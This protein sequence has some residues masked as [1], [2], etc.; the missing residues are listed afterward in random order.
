[1]AMAWTGDGTMAF[2]GDGTQWLQ[3]AAAEARG[4]GGELGGTAPSSGMARIDDETTSAGVEEKSGNSGARLES[5]TSGLIG[6]GCGA[7]RRRRR[8]QRGSR[9]RHETVAVA[10]AHDGGGSGCRKAGKRGGG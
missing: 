1:M 3:Q 4:G 8:W 7:R 10:A 5:L 2:V 9:R 6:S